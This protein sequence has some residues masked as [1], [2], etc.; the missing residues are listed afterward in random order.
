MQLPKSK[1]TQVIV[2]RIE[3]QDT[4]RQ[5]LETLVV[6]QSVKNVVV[7]TAVVGGVAAATYIGYKSAKAFF[8]WGH[9]AIDEVKGSYGA[10]ALKYMHA[11]PS[12][13]PVISPLVKTGE[14]I[15]KLFTTKP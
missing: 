12:G 6:G 9:D 13:I 11:S 10:L 8:T 5:A 2:H 4:E 1:P 14:L 7:P 3:L 15:F